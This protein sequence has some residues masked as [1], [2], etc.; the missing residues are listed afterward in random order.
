MTA[1]ANKRILPVLFL[2][3]LA[4]VGCSIDLSQAVTP[5][6]LPVATSSGT[7]LPV[8]WGDLNLAG[9]LIYIDAG[10]TP[11]TPDLSIQSLD[12]KT[13]G[14]TT[15]FHAPQDAWIYSVTVSPDHRQLVM[16]YAPP[17]PDYSKRRPALYILPMDGSQAPQLLFPP[18]TP[19][20]EYTQPVWSPDGKTIYYSHALYKAP[21]KNG[22]TNLD[23]EIYRMAYP[24]GPREKI[25][26]QA[27]WT[28]V[29]PDASRIVY[30]SIEANG[31][32]KLF[33]ANAD[34]SNAQQIQMTA[35]WV[36]SYIDAPVF[37]PDE[38]S[39]LFSAVSLNQSSAPGWIERLLGVTVAYAHNVESDW[40][41]VPVTGGETR[42]LTHYRAISLF[43][44]V[45]PDKQYIASY[46]G[47][48][49]FVM[50]PDGTGAKVL[51]NKSGIVPSS[52]SWIP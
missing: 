19:Q 25:A 45:S 37:S 14:I 11:S 21:A 32:N 2:S 24:G 31:T 50:K 30:V 3:A 35:H 28:N 5:A 8:T 4:L 40:W 20:D 48:G 39:I 9:R 43:A 23:M 13:G 38:K 34:G 26:S 33:L 51:N 49:M 41:T 16:A 29:S 52:V 46:S 1:S 7:S 44:S 47:Y 22:G 17:N 42:Q 15:I 12:L 27:F 10:P 18:E 6:P 36:P